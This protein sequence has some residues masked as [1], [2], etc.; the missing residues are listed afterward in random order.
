MRLQEARGDVTAD[1]GALLTNQ[2]Q[3]FL[4]RQGIAVA[5]LYFSDGTTAQPLFLSL[6]IWNSLKLYC[7]QSD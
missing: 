1:A 7:M 2:K 5:T 3:T 4:Y 6:S